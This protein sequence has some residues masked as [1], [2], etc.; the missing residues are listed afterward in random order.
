M[1]AWVRMLASAVSLV[2]I[3]LT[4]VETHGQTTEDADELFRHRD[5]LVKARRAADI[6]AS[7]MSGDFD[8]AWKLARV[9]Y[10]IGSHGSLDA[11]RNALERGIAAG[12][13]AIRLRPERAEGHF[14]LAANMGVLAQS[15]GITQGIKYRGRIKDELERVI[16]ID[17]SWQGGSA[18]GALGQ[19]YFK[20]P[21]LF[22]GSH[23]KAEA[24]LRAA[25][26]YDPDNRPALSTLADLLIDDGR[27]D[28]ARAVLQRI[29]AAPIDPDW[30]PEDNEFK[31]KAADRLDALAGRH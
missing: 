23:S 24:H 11:R 7:K 10:W 25:L 21:R 12:E 1:S 22:G 15:Y 4:A 14:W 9:C 20:V 26:R 28:E 18:D 31:K 13:E 27:N 29:L 3:L 16:A 8:A 6:W 19:W 5:D 30:L 2:C 17:P